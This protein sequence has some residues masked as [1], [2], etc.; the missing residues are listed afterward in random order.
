MTDRKFE[1]V[2]NVTLEVVSTNLFYKLA[3]H[4]KFLAVER[5]YC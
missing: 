1:E 3:G 4:G 2:Q 5:I